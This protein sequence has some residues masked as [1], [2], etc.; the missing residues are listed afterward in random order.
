MTPLAECLTQ[1]VYTSTQW[2]KAVFECPA[3]ILRSEMSPETND[4]EQRMY[5]VHNGMRA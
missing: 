4:C 2:Y 3:D 5:D 1:Q